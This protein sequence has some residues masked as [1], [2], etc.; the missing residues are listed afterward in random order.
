MIMKSQS[1]TNRI[2][3]KL[4]Y[5]IPSVPTMQVPVEDQFIPEATDFQSLRN[6]SLPSEVFAEAG[7]KTSLRSIS[8]ISTTPS[9]SD[10]TQ[11]EKRGEES[12]FFYK[13]SLCQR[14][15]SSNNRPYHLPCPLSASIQSRRHNHSSNEEC[16][17]TFCRDCW[18]WVYSVAICWTC[19]EI[20]VRDEERVGFGWCWW[21]WGCL[22]CLLCKVRAFSMNNA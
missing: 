15:L 11:S 17:R 3:P 12:V 16:G 21:H 6:Q 4:F 14:T 2:S 20:V 1:S 9:Q 19:G 8:T 7:P 18:I 5:I 10:T 13:C 22:G